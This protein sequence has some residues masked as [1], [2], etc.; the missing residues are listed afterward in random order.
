MAAKLPK[1]SMSL[2]D[3]LSHELNT[4]SSSLRA[5]LLRAEEGRGAQSYEENREKVEA[6]ISA[7]NWYL[8]NVEYLGITPED[9]PSLD[10]DIGG[11]IEERLENCKKVVSYME[12]LNRGLHGEEDPVILMGEFLEPFESG[13]G[14]ELG[15]NAGKYSSRNIGV[16]PGAAIAAN[17]VAKNYVEHGR[18]SAMEQHRDPQL[19]INIGENLTSYM[20]EI[21]DNGRV[22][23]FEKGTGMRII[24][25]VSDIYDINSSYGVKESGGM[26]YRLELPKPIPDFFD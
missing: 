16:G 7:L 3:Q 1:N 26:K 17:T 19:E 22:D 4:D 21:E 5:G 20:L 6:A 18:D 15:T 13:A 12:D 11:E 14:N 9:G 25:E 23:D 24:D 8:D 2:K 10:Y